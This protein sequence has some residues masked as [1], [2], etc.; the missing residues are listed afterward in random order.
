MTKGLLHLQFPSWCNKLI[1]Y[2]N[3]SKFHYV[4][5]YAYVFIN[6]WEITDILLTSI[7]ILAEEKTMMNCYSSIGNTQCLVLPVLHEST[8]SV[9]INLVCKSGFSVQHKIKTCKCLSEL[10]CLKHLLN[11]YYS[12]TWITRTFSVETEYLFKTLFSPLL[13]FCT[14]L[15]PT[16][17]LTV[18]TIKAALT[19]KPISSC[20]HPVTPTCDSERE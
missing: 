11:I 19:I 4:E 17:F 14:K 1:E 9:S 18:Y 3:F 20:Q 2:R 6:W 12:G 15:V 13:C 5:T 16:F 10:F 7:S 8:F